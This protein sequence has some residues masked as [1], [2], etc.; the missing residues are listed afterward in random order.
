MIKWTNNATSVI[1]NAGGILIG[2]T[3]V[4]VTTGH[5]D[6]FPEVAAPDYFM[7]TFVDVSG[8]REIVKV[9][10]RAA[11]SDTMTI[12]RAQEGTAAR[13]FAQGSFVELRATAD[14]YEYLSTIAGGYATTLAM[15]GNLAPAYSI[16]MST[17]L[18]YDPN[19]ADR[20][21]NPSGVYPAGF[22]ITIINTGAFAIT[23]DAAGLNHAIGAGQMRTFYYDATGA[24]WH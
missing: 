11:A 23:F 12:V 4:T 18:F 22:A 1:A 20:E 2:A 19:G 21:V 24:A 6:R 3:S 7:M 16:G 9:T 15:T 5:G 14:T 17:I 8:N 10:A 13:A